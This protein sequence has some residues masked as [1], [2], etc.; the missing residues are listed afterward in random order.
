[1]NTPKIKEKE[2]ASV[3]PVALLSLLGCDDNHKLIISQLAGEYLAE[4]TAPLS[5][6]SSPEGTGFND[7]ISERSVSFAYS[8]V[9]SKVLRDTGNPIVS[10]YP[11]LYILHLC[12]QLCLLKI[13]CMNLNISKRQS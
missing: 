6:P 10:I 7:F 9:P 5:D 11:S 12:C 2:E 1:M 3:K 4:V 13:K 8:T